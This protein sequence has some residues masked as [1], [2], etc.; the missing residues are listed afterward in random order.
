[1][2]YFDVYLSKDANFPPDSLLQLL[3]A[4]AL[5]AASKVEVKTV[6]VKY[7]EEEPPLSE[8]LCEFMLDPEDP[9]MNAAILDD[10]KKKLFDLEFKMFKVIYSI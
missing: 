1:M 2:N 9:S 3:G 7:K 10:A 5:I 8:T 6:H 4:T